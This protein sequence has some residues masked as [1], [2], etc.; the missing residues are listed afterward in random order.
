[1]YF[2]PYVQNTYK[3]TSLFSDP[4]K[5]KDIAEEENQYLLEN[6]E[7]LKPGYQWPHTIQTEGGTSKTFENK[8]EFN[9]FLTDTQK[10]VTCGETTSN[11][12]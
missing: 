4:R 5:G 8:E 11:Y 6:F 2:P 12:R 7:H 3:A 1:M 9:N 10:L